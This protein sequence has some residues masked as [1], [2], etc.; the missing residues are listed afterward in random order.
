MTASTVEFSLRDFLSLKEDHTRGQIDF[1][2][3]HPF[4]SLPVCLSTLFAFY[5]LLLYANNALGL[6]ISN[7]SHSHLKA[8]ACF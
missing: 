7:F 4:G 3:C 6:T 1:F 8:S 5:L 2:P